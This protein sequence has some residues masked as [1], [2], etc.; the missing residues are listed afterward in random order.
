VGDS[1]L[2][3]PLTLGTRDLWYSRT[4]SLRS[5]PNFGEDSTEKMR[6][7]VFRSVTLVV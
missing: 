5:H 3:S 1:G 6:C 4:L 7:H 2:R